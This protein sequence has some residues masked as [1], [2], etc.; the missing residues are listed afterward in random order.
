MD[1]FFSNCL[2]PTLPAVRPPRTTPVPYTHQGVRPSL[3]RMESVG[4]SCPQEPRRVP[5]RL[6]PGLIRGINH[7]AGRAGGKGMW[8]QHGHR[9]LGILLPALPR[10]QSQP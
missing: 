10:R 5:E 9:G 6:E 7:Q 8:S 3:L 1:L 2:P 4:L